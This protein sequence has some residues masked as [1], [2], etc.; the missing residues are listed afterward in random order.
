MAGHD[1][2][3]GY[4]QDQIT[5]VHY[6]TLAGMIETPPDSNA[7]GTVSVYKDRMVMEGKGRIKD[8]VFLFQ[9]CQIDTDNIPV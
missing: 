9:Q 1:H 5:G 4:Y 2:D 6:L 3:G 8:Q 7:F